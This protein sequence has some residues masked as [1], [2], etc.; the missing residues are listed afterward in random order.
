MCP[1][2]FFGVTYSINPWMA[3]SIN[4][5]DTALAFKQWQQFRDEL[6]KA[7]AT[8]KLMTPVQSQPDMVFTANAGHFFPID[9]DSSEQ[10]FIISRM[11]HQKERG[12]EEEN[13]LKAVRRF[14][15]DYTM[16]ELPRRDDIAFEGE[17]D[18]IQAGM[19]TVVG[20]GPRTNEAGLHEVYKIIPNV[21]HVMPLR[22]IN[23]DFFQL[24]M[25]FFYHE[26]THPDLSLH[27]KLI[28]AYKQAFDETG[29]HLIERFAVTNGIALVWVTKEDAYRL[30]CNAVG[31]GNSIILNNISPYVEEHFEK[32]WPGELKFVR[33]K[34][35]EFLKAGGGAKSL[36]LEMPQGV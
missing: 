28:L 8:T 18:I 5:V 11:K 2:K 23:P 6:H 30:A 20:Y 21:R 13:F 7:G 34:L 31:I 27:R 26:F 33:V 1:A 15:P 3:D 14:A 36:V 35:T 22:L 29:Q 32:M 10:V 4:K 24:D 16:I 17:A 19:T 12:I 9:N 25:C